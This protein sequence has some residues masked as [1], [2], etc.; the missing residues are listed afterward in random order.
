MKREL[1]KRL[2][3]KK[4]KKVKE[5]AK[6][7]LESDTVDYELDS[8]IG[9]IEASVKVLENTK[10]RPLSGLITAAV[11][12]FLCLLAGG[13]LWVIRIPQVNVAVSIAC[14]TLN[15][16]LMEKWV[17]EESIEI[18]YI[19][20][21][22]IQ[23]IDAPG[24]GINIDSLNAP[25]YH[26]IEAKGNNVVLE[27][28]TLG[29]NGSVEIE[30]MPKQ[31]VISLKETE[32]HGAFAIT[33]TNTVTINGR[34][35]EKGK[36]LNY[37]ES[38]EFNVLGKGKIPTNIILG[39]KIPVEI[40]LEFNQMKVKKIDF[41]KETMSNTGNH[42]F[43]SSIS[44]GEVKLFDVPMTEKIFK[45]DLVS[46]DVSHLE[47]LNISF[48][49]QLYIYFDGKV[50]HLKI[51][52]KGYERRLAPTYLEYLYHK[53]R[54]SFFWSAV[55]FFWGILWGVHRLIFVGK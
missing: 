10:S 16:Q 26:K 2:E 13:M 4:D 32:M 41:L 47:H 49:D 52:P 51:G 48:K 53:K 28:L 35:N 45:K 43:E 36:N 3:L 1:L 55:L 11:I 24:L 6:K 54:L 21:E 12:V 23:S 33:D 39:L 30:M 40:P 19:R 38:I 22:N 17:L 29:E 7:L 20:V 46:F 34:K 27:K 31:L 5:A 9:W 37:P 44:G 14:E 50:S 18:D 25:E 42:L 8:K 15:V